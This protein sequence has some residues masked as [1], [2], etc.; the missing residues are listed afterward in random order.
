MR[1]VKDGLAAPLRAKWGKKKENSQK[2]LARVN[3]TS[4]RAS[5]WAGENVAR[6]WDHSS[7]PLVSGRIAA[8]LLVERRI[9]VRRGGR[10]RNLG[11]L[12]PGNF[13]VNW[14]RCG[15]EREGRPGCA[16]VG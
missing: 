1:A 2:V 10:V 14:G 7:H 13:E 8:A 6:S 16:G 3:G 9:L 15:F 5:G 12:S 4:R 11:F